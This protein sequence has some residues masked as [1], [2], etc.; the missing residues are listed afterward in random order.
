MV[1]VSGSNV[2][3]GQAISASKRTFALE[4]RNAIAIAAR[5]TNAKRQQDLVIAL[6]KPTAF[7]LAAPAAPAVLME[8]VP[9]VLTVNIFFLDLIYVIEILW[10]LKPFLQHCRRQAKVI[11]LKH[12]L[13]SL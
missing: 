12:F 7:Y 13:T 3:R 2:N 6:L 10:W 11:R 1:V 4:T 8:N 5:T 9:T